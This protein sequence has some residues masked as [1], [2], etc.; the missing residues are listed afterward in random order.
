MQWRAG[1]CWQRIDGRSDV[2]RASAR[3]YPGSSDVV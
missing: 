3:F 1:V 2:A